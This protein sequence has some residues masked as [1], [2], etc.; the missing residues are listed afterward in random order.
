MSEC[1]GWSLPLL[2]VWVQADE[3]GGRQEK[4]APV[5]GFLPPTWETQTVFHIPDFSLTQSLAFVGV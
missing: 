4:I 3:H 1:L 2:P 5:P